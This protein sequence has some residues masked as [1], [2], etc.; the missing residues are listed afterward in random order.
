MKLTGDYPKVKEVFSFSTD[1]ITHIDYKFDVID[2][3]QLNVLFIT[4]YGER[5]VTPL[6]YSLV[7]GITPTEEELV[8]IASIIKNFYF[9]KWERLKK[10]N[11]LEYDPLHNY[12]DKLT[13][14]I[15]DVGKENTQKNSTVDTDM[16]QG[17]NA[18]NTR[19]D[20]LSEVDVSKVESSDTVTSE[21]GVYGFNSADAVKSDDS[22]KTSKGA[23]TTNF[24]K[25][26][27][28]TQTNG[29]VSAN[30]NKGTVKESNINVT[31]DNKTQTRT[32][33]HSG[34]IGNLTT[35]Q[36]FNQEV[37]LRKWNFINSVL[38]DLKELLTLPIYM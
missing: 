37:E 20:N 1:V 27:T 33:E 18:T 10:L 14:T 22:S 8:K 26:N 38:E 32:S 4:N 7:N 21:D 12:S 6:V 17:I 5:T 29:T 25:N 11:N 30:T 31:E 24:S 19:T 2:S 16:T 23:E 36:L 13:E 35:Q 3:S 9:V 34:N 15:T 28:G